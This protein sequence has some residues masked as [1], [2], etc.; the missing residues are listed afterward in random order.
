MEFVGAVR[1][2]GGVKDFGLGGGRVIVCGWVRRGG[3]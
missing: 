3:G 2:E 1:L